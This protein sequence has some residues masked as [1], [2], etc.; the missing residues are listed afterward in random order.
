MN[1]LITIII[2]VLFVWANAALGMSGGCCCPA[3][4]RELIECADDGCPAAH[5]DSSCN[6]KSAASRGCND[7]CVSLRCPQELSPVRLTETES[8]LQQYKALTLPM[9][10]IDSRESLKMAWLNT[11]PF[12]S[13]PEEPVS[14][15]LQTCSFL[16]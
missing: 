4:T 16:S 14:L 5:H 3:D 6:H 12:L 1:R 2:M 13:R 8:V 9:A 7:G 11:R 15:L 10:I